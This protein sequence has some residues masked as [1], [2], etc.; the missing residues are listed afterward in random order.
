MAFLQEKVLFVWFMFSLTSGFT[1]SRS[2]HYTPPNLKHLTELFPRLKFNQG[3]KESFGESNIKLMDNGSFVNVTLDKSSGSGFVSQD[4]YYYGFFNTAIKLPAGFSSGV[5]VAFY[6]SSFFSLS[7]MSNSEIFPHNHDEIDIELLGHQ[8]RKEWILQT[9]IYGN[10][11]IKTGREEKF[12]LWFD[13]TEQHHQYSIIWNS[14]HTVFLVDNVPIREVTHSEGISSAY[15]LKPMSLHCTIWDGSEWAT[16]GGKDP[17]NYKYAP[18]V[19]S[20]G[21]MQMEGCKWDKTKQVPFCVK[22][23]QGL[24]ILDPVEGEEFA[25]LSQEQK[26]GMDDYRKRFMIYSYCK[27]PRRYKVLPPECNR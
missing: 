9:N 1:S 25:K 26:M 17:V 2:D 22:S 18:F 24:S 11:S 21:D 12:H 7:L 14:N 19:A 23:G 6:V 5:V 3:F 8:N 27:D 16:N 4:D 20:F 13:P 15:P 10:G